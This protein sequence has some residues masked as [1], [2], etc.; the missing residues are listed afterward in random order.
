MK[1]KIQKSKITLHELQSKRDY[2]VNDLKAGREY[3]QAY[4]HFIHYVESS[5]NGEE[6]KDSHSEHKH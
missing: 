1:N 2:N 3:V 4:V 6:V 5:F